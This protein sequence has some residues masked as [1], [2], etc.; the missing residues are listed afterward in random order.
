MFLNTRVWSYHKILDAE[1]F[2]LFSGD[3]SDLKISDVQSD[4]FTLSIENHKDES[5]EKIFGRAHSIFSYYLSVV[6]KNRI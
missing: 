4:S 1:A 5:E 3:E 6:D 2:E